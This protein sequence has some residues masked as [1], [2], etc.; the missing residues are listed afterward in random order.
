MTGKFED[1]ISKS[2][3]GGKLLD[4][5]FDDEKK[6]EFGR[7]VTNYSALVID[8]G[9]E[10]GCSLVN[11]KG[12][13]IDG[14]CS[15]ISYGFG[16]EASETSAPNFRTGQFYKGTNYSQPLISPISRIIRLQ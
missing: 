8:R 10:T 9:S 3:K 5:S 13:W 11:N 1:K 4:V 14:P 7:L 16:C 15:A 12:D 2:V 6:L